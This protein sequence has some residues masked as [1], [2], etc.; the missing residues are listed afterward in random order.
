V[1]P[2]AVAKI[3][4]LVLDLTEIAYVLPRGLSTERSDRSWPDMVGFAEIHALKWD[5][6]HRAPTLRPGDLH[7]WKIATAGQGVPPVD[8]LWSLLSDAERERASRLRLTL[9]RERYLRAQSGLRRILASYMDCQPEALVFLRGS[10]GKPYLKDMPLYFNLSTSGDLAL[11]GVSLQE[12]VG[13]DCERVRR[14]GELDG[15][16]RRMFPPALA[17][18]VIAAPYPER[19]GHFYR[20]WTALEADV[21]SDGRGLFGHKDDPGG[22]DALE[23]DHCKPEP[24][25]I[26]AVARVRLPSVQHWRALMLEGT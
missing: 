25:F 1:T 7:L 17:A 13:V 9:H 19:L 11:L 10:A 18:L 26:A 22:G 12:A 8:D 6:V 23:I 15:V 2:K 3:S 14:R 20:A 4:K 21:K 16:A 5:K 24:G